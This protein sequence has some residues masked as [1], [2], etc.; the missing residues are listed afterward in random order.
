MAVFWKEIGFMD[1]RKTLIFFIVMWCALFAKTS[2]STAS[3]S[4]DVLELIAGNPLKV[5]YLTNWS[6]QN[7][8]NE[9]FLKEAS[10]SG[11]LDYRHHRDLFMEMNFDIDFIGFDPDKAEIRLERNLTLESIKTKEYLNPQ[12]VKFISFKKGRYFIS[13]KI[14]ES[15][16]NSAISGYNKMYGSAKMVNG[17]YLFCS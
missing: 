5:A 15:S 14:D 4:C 12:L 17:S 13:I 10:I 8:S 3:N 1:M 9:K 6:R 7:V 11:H 16:D 2:Y